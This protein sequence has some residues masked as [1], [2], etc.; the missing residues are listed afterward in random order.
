MR[1]VAS[2]DYVMGERRCVMSSG[3]PEA[4]AVIMVSPFGAPLLLFD[5]HMIRYGGDLSI[6]QTDAHFPF[7]RLP[8]ELG[9]RAGFGGYVL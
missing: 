5:A 7:P 4:Y 6:V 8:L 3:N 9:L 2:V 1:D